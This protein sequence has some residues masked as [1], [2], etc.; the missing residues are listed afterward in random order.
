MKLLQESPV[1]FLD[2][3]YHPP[4][5]VFITEITG[6]FGNAVLVG[7]SNGLLS[8]R[9]NR[10]HSDVA[11]TISLRWG[12]EIIF[13]ESPF[14]VTNNNI[15]ETVRAFLDGNSVPIKAVVQP[16]M[17]TPFTVNVHRY[18]SRI[19]FGETYS[20]GEIAAAMGNP[21]AS[22][23]VGT[24]CGKNSVLIVVPCHRVVASN[25]LGGFGAGL[26][27]KKR[28]LTHEGVSS[29]NMKKSIIS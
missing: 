15:K 17:L 26:D 24:A 13:D 23:A 14:R 9:L 29:Y 12:S 16:V 28:L 10:R 5:K 6:K 11:E 2:P 3:L 27:L 18:I 8:L 4:E 20:Y 7:T 21:R 1:E 22:R 19:P 25:G